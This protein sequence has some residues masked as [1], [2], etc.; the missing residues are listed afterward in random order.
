MLSW[1]PEE[2]WGCPAATSYSLWLELECQVERK[3][4]TAYQALLCPAKDFELNC[5]ELCFPDFLND[6]H[7][8]VDMS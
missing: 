4:G 1:G 7:H 3:D 2:E 6:K 8:L 5:V